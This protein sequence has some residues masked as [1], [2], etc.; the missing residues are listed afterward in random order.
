MGGS[1]LNDA[2]RDTIGRHIA[3]HQNRL[4]A[5]AFHFAKQVFRSLPALIVMDRHSLRPVPQK[6]AQEQRQCR[7]MRR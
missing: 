3:L 1:L 5:L 2:F 6:R 4:A 7:S